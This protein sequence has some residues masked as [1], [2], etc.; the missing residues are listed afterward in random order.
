MTMKN[1]LFYSCKA[2][3]SVTAVKAHKFRARALIAA[4]EMGQIF[5]THSGS[6]RQVHKSCDGTWMTTQPD[7]Y[8]AANL[9]GVLVK[10][11]LIN[12]IEEP[13]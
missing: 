9:K 4:G 2:G 12:C 5:N 10:E 6:Q 1:A 7:P 3:L 8:L 11:G 13:A